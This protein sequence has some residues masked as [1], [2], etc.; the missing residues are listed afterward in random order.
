MF[1][2]ISFF[3]KMQVA[4]NLCKWLASRWAD[5]LTGVTAVNVCVLWAA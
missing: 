1:L 4:L 2:L 5:S 3:F